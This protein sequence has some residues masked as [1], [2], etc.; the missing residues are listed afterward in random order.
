[1][2]MNGNN[3]SG[4]EVCGCHVDGGDVN[5]ACVDGTI[6]AVTFASI[7]TPVTS[8]EY[9]TPRH[10]MY[11]WDSPLFN[12]QMYWNGRW[13]RALHRRKLPGRPCESKSHG[14]DGV[15]GEG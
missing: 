10:L 13:L 12:D 1:M 5:L 9:W 14:G 11:H 7:G 8:G 2:C 3:V 6:T 4:S 15:R